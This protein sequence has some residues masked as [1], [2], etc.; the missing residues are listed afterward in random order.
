MAVINIITKNADD[1]KG[2]DVSATG[3][4]FDT[5]KFNLLAGGSYEKLQ[6]SGSI[7]YLNTNG[8]KLVI[9]KDRFAGQSYTAAP[10]RTD[11]NLEKTDVFLKMLYGDLSFKGQ[12]VN[13]DRGAYIGNSYTLTDENFITIHCC[14]K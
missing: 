5:K 12:Y 9:D 2:V 1:I 6:V 11:Q 10:G 3:G 8:P 7:D 14:P 4:S 13:K